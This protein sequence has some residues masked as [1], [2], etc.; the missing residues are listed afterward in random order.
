M[1]N[2]AGKEIKA[3]HSKGHTY[4][5]EKPSGKFELLLILLYL[6]V[7]LIPQMGS[8]EVMGPQWLY[9][10]ILNLLSIGFIIL[11]HRNTLYKLQSFLSK[12]IIVLL[13]IAVFVL[14][15]ISILFALN[16]TES[17][18]VYSR[19]IITL[20]SFFIICT[21]IYCHPNNINTIFQ[22]I[23]IITL[24]QCFYLLNYFI[25]NIGNISI[26]SLILS[27]S[28]NAGNKN[29]L[30]ASF[31]IKAPIIIYCVFQYFSWWRYAINIVSLVLVVI[32]IF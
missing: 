4:N 16:P 6:V 3:N 20:L 2:K 22:V 23:S 14:C 31:V 29:V 15:G 17:I 27:L 11:K 28:G 19:F 24:I 32:L 12:N 5:Q 30:A 13:Y 9:I 8:I 7:D 25:K 26:D 10:S 21:L 18:V 1:A